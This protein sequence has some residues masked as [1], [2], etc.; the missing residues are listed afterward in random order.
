MRLLHSCLEYKL[1]VVQCSIHH[2]PKQADAATQYFAARFLPE[3]QAQHL[4]PG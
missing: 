1:L 2:I 3:L 4:K